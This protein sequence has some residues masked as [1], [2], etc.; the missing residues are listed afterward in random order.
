MHIVLLCATRRGLSFFHALSQ[1]VPDASI[2]VFS[3]REAEGEPPFFDDIRAATASMRRRFIEARA[4]YGHAH[5]EFWRE[6]PIDLLFAVS[7]RYLV[8][9]E[10]FDL[11]VLGSFVFHDSLLP[12]N[13]GFSPTVWAIANGDDHTGVTLFEMNDEVDSGDIVDQQ[14]VSIGPHETIREALAHTTEAY[15][16]VLNRNFDS[17]RSGT[18]R[19][20]PQVQSDATYCRRRSPEDNR[21]DWD[22]DVRA[23][24]N[25]IRAVT[26]PYPGAF[27]TLRGKRL[28]IWAARPVDDSIDVD[29]APGTVVEVHPGRGIEVVTAR[30]KL[31]VTTVQLE[32]GPVGTAD[33]FVDRPGI[34][35]GKGTGRVT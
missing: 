8:P 18:A 20:H 16:S 28:T 25:L 31:L 32:T 3:F 4:V 30:G 26:D 6:D 29:L 15:I 10:A 35:L 34:R 22:R 23:I 19:R 5:R 1:L 33:K 2:T 14:R 9:R 13:R 27:T 24:Y 11:P 17:L 12:R 7:W 21:I